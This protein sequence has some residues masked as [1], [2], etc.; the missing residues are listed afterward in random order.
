MRKRLIRDFIVLIL[1]VSGI[2]GLFAWFAAYGYYER[3]L[4]TRLDNL[5]VGF[6]DRLPSGD[7][8][9][10]E[11]LAVHYAS[12]Y[13][14]RVSVFRS[15]GSVIADTG[16]SQAD[17]SDRPEVIRAIR[18]GTG[19]DSRVSATLGEVLKYFA[20]RSDDG[21][22]I[23]RMAM[24]VGGIRQI[25]NA[26]LAYILCGALL[27]LAVAL[28]MAFRF[29]ERVAG[30]IAQLSDH[31][32]KLAEGR[33]DE[34]ITL[35]AEDEVSRLSDAFNR[36]AEKIRQDMQEIKALETVRREFVANVT[37]ELRTPLTSIQGF[38]E[39]LKGGAYDDKSTAYRFLDIIDTEADRLARLIDDILQLS[40]VE[41]L[42]EDIHLSTFDAVRLAEETL[43]FLIPAAEEKKVVLAGEYGESPLPIRANRDRIKG[44]LLNLMDNAI[45]YNREGG[46][47]AVRLDREGDKL[48][49]RV[50]DTGMGMEKVH[51]SRIFERFYRVDRG[52]SRAT[53]GTG[54]G[55][56]I[57]KHIVQL[58]R[59]TVDVESTPG[60]GSTFSFEL[61][62]RATDTAK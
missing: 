47:V 62:N 58:Y 28:V 6:L 26:I 46:S 27:A 18:D 43:L 16:G 40:H 35:D 7:T 21:S 41:V 8:G 53:G 22:V 20:R 37:H 51:L 17:H 61:P 4:E 14:V 23:I 60:E 57:V 34:V 29:T 30:P 39:T 3:E 49:I 31:A 32:G 54:L 56:S 11:A 59:G 2:M 25:R 50:K 5:C 42:K 52:R 48:V 33:Y 24:S 10:V 38:I 45:R 13:E 55:L 1:I 19:S 36:M 12:L 44:I 9:Q 15:D